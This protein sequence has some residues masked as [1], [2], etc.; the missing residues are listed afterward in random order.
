LGQCF[1][2]DIGGT[3]AKIVFFEQKDAGDQRKRPR[4]PSHDLAVGEMTQILQQNE[5]LGKT[6]VHDVRLRVHSKQLGGVRRGGARRFLHASS[7]T[8]L[9]PAVPPLH[10]LREQQDARGHRVHRQHGHQ[11]VHA[12]AAVYRWRRAQGQSVTA[13]VTSEL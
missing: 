1:G 3:L 8:R 12:H 10:P 9:L 7:L 11:P 13:V 5:A 4:S 6:G 2:L